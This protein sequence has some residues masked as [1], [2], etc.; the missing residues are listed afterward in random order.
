MTPMMQIYQKEEILKKDKKNTYLNNIYETKRSL[1]GDFETTPTTQICQKKKKI[2]K[3]DKQKKR[4][5]KSTRTTF[6]QQR[7]HSK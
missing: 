6:M 5:K 2:L 4:Q 1:H 3:K 7:V